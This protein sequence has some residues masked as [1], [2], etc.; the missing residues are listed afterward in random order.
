MARV[1]VG[2][3]GEGGARELLNRIQRALCGS[4]K[5]INRFRVVK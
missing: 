4:P 2:W 3:R 5:R 1:V